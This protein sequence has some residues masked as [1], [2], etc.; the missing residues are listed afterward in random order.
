MF[1]C[2]ECDYRIVIYY[3]FLTFVENPYSLRV[4]SA[5][6]FSF[7]PHPTSTVVEMAYPFSQL[8]ETLEVDFLAVLV[9]P[10][11]PAALLTP[12][13][14]YPFGPLPSRPSS[15]ELREARSL[16]RRLFLLLIARQT[17]LLMSFEVG[18]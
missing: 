7:I 6:S 4:K 2:D 13:E 18:C 17:R 14:L 9:T 3:F 16:T 12:S 5:G 8:G 10:R 11:L 1:Y 15:S